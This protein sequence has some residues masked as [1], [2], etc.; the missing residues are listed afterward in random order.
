MV[1]AAFGAGIDSVLRSSVLV[2][3]AVRGGVGVAGVGI[4]TEALLF[5]MVA[6]SVIVEVI[7]VWADVVVATIVSDA[8]VA[9]DIHRC[10]LLIPPFVLP[11]VLP[12]M[13]LPLMLP[14]VLLLMVSCRTST[15]W[16]Q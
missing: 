1:S 9:V 6:V 5:D 8:T 11:L 2:F 12:L 4:G 15:G 3:D 14:L 10:L 13:F 7:V 16:G